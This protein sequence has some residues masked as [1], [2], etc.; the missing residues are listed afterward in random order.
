MLLPHLASRLYGTPLLLARTKLDIILAVLG[1][2]VGWPE[3][4]TALALPQARASPQSLASSAAGIA[5]I[6]VHGSLVRRS[7]AMDAQSGLTSYGDIASMLDE[8]ARDPGVAG[9][10]LDIDSPGGEAG[11]VFELSRKIRDINAIKPVWAVASDGAYSAAY[12]IASA[13]SRVFVTETGGVGSIGVIAMHVDQSAR[14]AKEG[15]RFTAISAGDMKN[16]LSPHEPINKAAMTRL[17]TEVD[18]LYGLFVDHVAAMRGLDAKAIRATEAGL[19]FGPDAVRTGLADSLASPDLAVAEFSAYLSVQRIQNS[20]ARVISTTAS[21]F[22]TTHISNQKEI[23]MNQDPASTPVPAVPVAP[24]DTTLEDNGKQP[25]VLPV[26]VVPAAPAA[27]VQVDPAVAN[28]AITAASHAAGLA[29][30]AEALTIAELC[31]LAGQ[32]QRITGFLA[33]GATSTQVRQT[34]LASRAQSEEISS[35]IHP[36][37]ALKANPGNANDAGALMAAVKRL[38]QKP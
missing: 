17:Q 24:V 31:Q 33:Q 22:T 32:S 10:L 34:L 8:A 27:P 16:D 26:P 21:A 35:V 36:D 5:V 1:S 15:Y 2:R 7:L 14:D 11:G 37:A 4:Q 29:A 13:A 20:A 12:A 23:H 30:R 18:R 9:I 25:K 38:T 3:S 6:P 19:Y 28:D